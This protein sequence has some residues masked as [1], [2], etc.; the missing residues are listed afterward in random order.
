MAAMVVASSASAAAGMGV[1]AVSP[2]C[3]S[4]ARP[5]QVLV[6]SRRR[7]CGVVGM[8]VV[9]VGA[10]P[11]SRGSGFSVLRNALAENPSPVR[12][13]SSPAEFLP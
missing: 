2:C 3:S 8:S 5:Q 1:G 9:L 6:A 11:R 13:P 7:V 10:Q 4:A 12:P